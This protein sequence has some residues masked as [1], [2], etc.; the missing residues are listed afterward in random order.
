MSFWEQST[1]ESI[2]I[3]EASTK[4]FWPTSS[5]HPSYAFCTQFLEGDPSPPPQ[6]FGL[7]C[8]AEAGTS[9]ESWVGLEGRGEKRVISCAPRF[10]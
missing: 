9:A 6:T 4:R 2:M 10:I 3:A 1:T 7:M 8:L 5:H